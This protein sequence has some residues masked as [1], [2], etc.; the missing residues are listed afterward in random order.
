MSVVILE[1][2]VVVSA[3]EGL[4]DFAGANFAGRAGHDAAE[5]RRRVIGREDEGVGEEGVAEE[6]GRMGTVGAIGRIAAMAGIGA[7]EDIVVHE[8]SQV[9]Q[10]DDAGSADEGLRRRAAGA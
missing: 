2:E 5:F 9:D 8:G 1:G 6:Y 7:V 3:G 4:A 10:F